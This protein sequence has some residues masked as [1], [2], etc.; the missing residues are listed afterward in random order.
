MSVGPPSSDSSSQPVPPQISTDN[1]PAAGAS[2]QNVSMPQAENDLQTSLE[3]LQA[4]GSNAA[5]AVGELA[6][7]DPK[8]ANLIAVCFALLGTS[9]SEHQRSL[10]NKSKQINLNT[11][12]QE[13]INKEQLN[14]KF[15]DFDESKATQ[16]TQQQ[17]EAYTKSQENQN[18]RADAIKQAFQQM[19]GTLTQQ[20]KAEMTAAGTDSSGIEQIA[21]QMSELANLL[22]KVT[23]AVNTMLKGG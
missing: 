18:I 15:S 12:T 9:L 3:Q 21:N 4:A 22:Q 14:I 10:L 11:D 5:N 2:G 20:A 1:I 23:S 8:A 19:V 16:G 13:K 6:K 7:K 17:Q